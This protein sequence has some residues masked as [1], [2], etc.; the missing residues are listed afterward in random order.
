MLDF[1]SH[2]EAPIS[3]QQWDE[4]DQTVVE[5][6]R[7]QLVGRR[8]ISVFGPLGAGIQWTTQDT[9]EGSTQGLINALGDKDQH[10]IQSS[11]RQNLHIPMLYKDF[12]FYWRDIEASRKFNIPLDLSAAAAAASVCARTEDELIFRGHRDSANGFDYPGL[13]TVT[14]RQVIQK[15]NWDEAGAV[16]QD[17]IRATE[18]LAAQGYYAP[19]AMVVPPA[20]YSKIHRYVNTSGMMEIEYI[21]QIVTHG[22]YFS[23]V[24]P[25]DRTL[26]VSTGVQNMDLA[27]AQDLKT[28]YLGAENMN[29]PFRVF[30]TL[31]L[32][33]K[34]PGAICVIEGA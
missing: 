33:I 15:G 9:F 30:E 1:L 6:A 24:I 25:A 28:A 5:V 23:S 27:I 8:F 26:V 34:R 16:F 13:L 22:V 32:R 2:N 19:Y 21:R 12:V 11:F 31:A 3:D 20:L 29:H 10:P 14:G 17:V 7:R 18:T 4:I